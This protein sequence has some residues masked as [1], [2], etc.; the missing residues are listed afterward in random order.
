MFKKITATL[1]NLLDQETN[2]NFVNELGLQESRRKYLASEN[3]NELENLS[4]AY[5]HEVNS[6]NLNMLMDTLSCFFEMSF[7][8]KKPLLMNTTSLRRLTDYRA[9][10]VSLFGQ[11]IISN[12]LQVP[13]KLPK[14]DLYKVLKTKAHSFL[15]KFKLQDLDSDKKMSCYLIRISENVTLVF[16]TDMAD[17]WAKVKIETLQQTLMR[18]NFNL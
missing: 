18:I 6:E 7:V 8:F 17:P 3:L 4:Y 16:V 15:R 13:A 12:H 14:A 10:Y 5:S 1:E 11:K 2:Q 9:E